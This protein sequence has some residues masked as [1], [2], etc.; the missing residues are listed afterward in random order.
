MSE[1]DPGDGGRDRGGERKPVSQATSGRPRYEEKHSHIRGRGLISSSA[2][3]LAD[4][5]ITNIAFLTGF[6]EVAGIA[7]VR[8]AGVAALLAGSVSM[9]FGGLLAARSE[10][11]LFNADARREAYEIEHER[12]EELAE[13]KD[14]YI[15]K[16]LTVQE[17]NTVVA[18]VSSSKERFLE[19]M[20]ANELHIH[21]SNLE[22]PYKLAATVGLSFFVGALV[23]LA[24]Y[25][26]I[27]VEEY[28]TVASV[29]VSLVFLFSAGV[30]KGGIVG[31]SPWRTGGETLAIGAAAAGI[32]FVIGKF[33]GFA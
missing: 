7:V 28:A 29:V 3:G 27:G 16:G 2:L 6:G 22:N 9:F 18:R 19:D 26:L 1:E 11:D 21:D 30:W 14:L 4:G 13:L 32:L 15:K 20:L 12:E 17:A 10:F 5:L 23:P 24:P 33:V 25:Y 31:R 8:L